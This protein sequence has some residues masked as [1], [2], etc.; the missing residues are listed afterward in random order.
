MQTFTESLRKELSPRDVGG[1][2]CTVRRCLTRDAGAGAQRVRIP[3]APLYKPSSG[4]L[5]V[6][7]F[8]SGVSRSAIGVLHRGESPKRG[9]PLTRMLGLNTRAPGAVTSIRTGAEETRRHH[10]GV[11]QTRRRQGVSRE[12]T[13]FLVSSI[14]RHN[15]LD[16]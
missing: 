12:S 8:L 16:S 1:L 2:A 9:R 10:S 11:L 13:S 4:S 7:R 15:A 14:M 5:V 3:L 6:L